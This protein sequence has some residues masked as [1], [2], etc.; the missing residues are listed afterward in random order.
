VQR[1]ETMVDD[2]AL[3]TGDELVGEIERFLQQGDAGG[4]GPI[5]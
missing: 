5:G 3:P 4:P 2:Q 1:L